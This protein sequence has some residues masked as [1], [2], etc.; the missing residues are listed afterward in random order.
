MEIWEKT[1]RYTSSHLTGGQ[2]LS[3]MVMF[4]YF[5]KA[6]MTQNRPPDYGIFASWNRACSAVV[7][8]LRLV[9]K[10]L[11]SNPAFSTKHGTCLFIVVE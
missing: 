8:A 1:K 5:S 6:C 7:I 10:V 4:F 9:P 11:G 2:N 3:L